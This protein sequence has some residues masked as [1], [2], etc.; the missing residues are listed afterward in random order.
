[1]TSPS[2]LSS[3][4]H[5]VGVVVLFLLGW[6][7]SP[8]LINK[9]FF[10]RL[11][12]ASH[13]THV[14]PSRIETRTLSPSCR[15][16]LSSVFPP[17][18]LQDL[19]FVLHRNGEPEPCGTLPADLTLFE[20]ALLSFDLC[21][22]SFDK[23]AFESWLTSLM[24]HISSCECTI[25]KKS[26][27]P[28]FLGYCDR[29]PDHTPLLP[30]HDRLVK[31]PSTN[32]LPCHFHTREGVRITSVEQFKEL[33]I[34][35]KAA[36]TCLPG[37]ENCGEQPS[38]PSLHLY[39]VTAGRV[40]MFAPKFVGEIFELA[41]VTGDKGAPISLKVLSIEP[42][43]FDIFNFFSR[44]EST[45]LVARALKE[46]SDSHRIKRSTTGA[47]GHAVNARRTSE[48][49][50]DT[51]GKVAVDVKKRCFKILGFDE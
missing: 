13:N 45:D 33:L 16:K 28:G 38:T 30:D 25:S 18:L 19:A 8:Q 12:G 2:A 14:D 9:E 43:V 48:S 46:T 37:D 32:T 27:A 17:D 29:G 21:L 39:A 34:A 7:L 15:R 4:L 10:V 26:I 22:D 36:P 1:M 23:Y 49:G 31:I 47:E 5:V 41:H 20:D 11:T 51:H 24:N 40:F 44:E 3:S 6:T 50:F 42:R 35:S